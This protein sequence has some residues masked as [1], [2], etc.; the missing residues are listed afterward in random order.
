PSFSG[1]CDFHRNL[2]ALRHREIVPRLPGARAIEAKV[3]GP[4]ALVAS[5]RLGDGA[6]LTIATN[7]AATPAAGA[8]PDGDVL[9]A[10]GELLA[11]YSTVAFLA[12]P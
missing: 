2:L 10:A 4:A 6:V 11:G 5:W 9:F 8:R 1:G 12:R 7:L 3:A